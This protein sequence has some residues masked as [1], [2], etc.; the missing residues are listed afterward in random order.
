[1]LFGR[2]ACTQ[3]RLSLHMK[4]LEKGNISSTK[5][6]SLS[7]HRYWPHMRCNHLKCLVKSTLS[8]LGSPTTQ[9]L[10]NGS[11]YLLQNSPAL[12]WITKA[13]VQFW[14]EPINCPSRRPP[15][16]KWSANM[17]FATKIKEA[18]AS[19]GNSFVV[20]EQSYLIISLMHVISRNSTPNMHVHARLRQQQEYNPVKV[21]DKTVDPKETKD[22]YDACWSFISIKQRHWP[23]ASNR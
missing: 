1:M 11:S 23:E 19:H 2:Y 5:V 4:E 15:S 16:I 20:R 7:C 22:L 3:D 13:I 6:L 14:T 10:F 9:I 8:L 18:I 21:W 17:W 12:Q